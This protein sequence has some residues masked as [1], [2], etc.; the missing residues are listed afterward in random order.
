MSL[1]SV[2]DELRELISEA[3]SSE[4]EGLDEVTKN[5]P[6]MRYNPLGTRESGGGLYGKVREHPVEVPSPKGPVRKANFMWHCKCP[7]GNCKCDRLS[8]IT[9]KML[10]KKW[11][12]N[13]KKKAAYDKAYRDAM[14][15]R[16]RT[17]S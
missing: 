10:T 17:R 7:G 1:R 12:V 4:A 16:E 11:T 8:A 6:F 9:G 5:F 3:D 14:R 13:K 15:G 2:V